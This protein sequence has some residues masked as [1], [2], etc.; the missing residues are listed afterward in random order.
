MMNKNYNDILSTIKKEFP[1]IYD[2][3]EML[4]NVNSIFVEKIKNIELIENDYNLCITYEETLE[5]TKNILKE[6]NINYYKEF[7]NIVKNNVISLDVENK[8]N[9]SRVTSN[10]KIIMKLNNN[11]S[12]ISTLI[13]EYTHYH[14][15]MNSKNKSPFNRQFLG[16]MFSITFEIYSIDEL[17]KGGIS[18]KNINFNK[19]IIFEKQISEF[20]NDNLK[21]ILDYYRTNKNILTCYVE[22]DDNILFARRISSHLIHLIGFIFSNYIV[23]NIDMEKVIEVND[24][25]NEYENIDNIF[26]NLNIDFKSNQFITECIDDVI[27]HYCSNKKIII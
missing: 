26:Y 7:E 18:K 14:H 21:N 8:Y 2:N 9:D 24:N 25:I 27:E 16:E 15:L 10:G 3:F 11:Y 12:D 13:H 17:L 6:I 5:Y 19:R 1:Y 4:C 20:Y 22:D 23:K